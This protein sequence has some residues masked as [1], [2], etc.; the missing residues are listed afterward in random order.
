MCE[1]TTLTPEQVI[2]VICQFYELDVDRLVK[3]IPETGRHFRTTPYVKGRQFFAYWMRKNTLL[4]FKQ[5]GGYMENMHWATMI[6][7]FETVADEINLYDKYKKEVFQLNQ[8]IQD[9]EKSPELV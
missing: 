7:S 1:P 2:D 6:H 9:V 4:T 5:I 8:L 3:R